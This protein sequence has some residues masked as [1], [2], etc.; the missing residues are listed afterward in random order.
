MNGRPGPV[1]QVLPEYMLTR[2]TDAR[3]LP[4]VGAVQNWDDPDALQTLRE[5]LLKSERPFV[6]AGGSGW[7]PQSAQAP[8]RFAENWKL[9]V[10]NA[11]RFQDTFDNRHPLYAGDLGIGLTPNWPHASR[12]ATS[13]L[14]WV[15]VW[16][17]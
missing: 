7:T 3:S 8:Q 4:R 16:A 12:P 17:K 13:S 11:F 5:M 2:L 10:D 6:I 1:A 9:P 15:R 14:P